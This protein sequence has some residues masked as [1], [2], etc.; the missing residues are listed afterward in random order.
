[1]RI[2]AIVIAIAV[3]VQ[4]GYHELLYRS[5]TREV[6][7]ATFRGP[8]IKSCARDARNQRITTSKKAW[9]N[10]STMKLVIGKDDIDVYFWQVSN[11]M[12]RARYKNPYLFIVAEKSSGHV[13]CE[14]DIV[15]RSASVQRM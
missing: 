6:I 8:A 7:V 10:P 3:G 11:S 12:W 13:L 2:L 4:L 15:H 5:A 1:M 9:R 14:Y